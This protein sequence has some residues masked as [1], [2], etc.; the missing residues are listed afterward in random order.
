VSITRVEIKLVQ[1]FN[2]LYHAFI[3]LLTLPQDVK[4]FLSLTRILVTIK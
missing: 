4:P 2:S 1:K 3:K